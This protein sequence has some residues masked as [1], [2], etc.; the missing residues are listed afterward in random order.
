MGT[1]GYRTSSRKD[2]RKVMVRVGESKALHAG[3]GVC[4]E[5]SDTDFTDDRLAIVLR[6]LSQEPHGS[7]RAKPQPR[8]MRIYDLP[9][10]QVADATTCGYHL[11]DEEGCFSLD[12]VKTTPVCLSS[13][14][15]WQT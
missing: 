13:K 9:V 11:V 5:I 10:Q 1:T 2:H 7:H 3:A 6:Q 14:R 15:C 4:I 12:I 8:T